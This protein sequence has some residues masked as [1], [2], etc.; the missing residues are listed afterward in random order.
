MNWEDKIE[1]LSPFYIK[2][3]PTNRSQERKLEREVKLH[4]KKLK[5]I[6]DA[7][8]VEL[9]SEKWDYVDVY[10]HYADIFNKQ[11]AGIKPKHTILNKKYFSQMYKP[12]ENIKL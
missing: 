4:N 9:M 5:W 2:Q 12:V 6:E 7:F 11:M 3:E 8:F 1:K 10:N